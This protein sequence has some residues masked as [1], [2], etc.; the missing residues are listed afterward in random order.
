MLLKKSIS[1]ILL[2]VLISGCAATGENWKKATAE[3]IVRYNDPAL[4]DEE[5]PLLKNGLVLEQRTKGKGIGGKVYGFFDGSRI[6]R[7]DTLSDMIP[8]VIA[9]PL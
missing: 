8:D 9:N 2:I 1:V 4:T 7:E 5:K 6:E 3:D